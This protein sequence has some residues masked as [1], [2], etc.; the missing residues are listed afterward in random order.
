M[1]TAFTTLFLFN[2][3]ISKWWLQTKRILHEGVWYRQVTISFQ[4]VN[5]FKSSL[6]L[7]SKCSKKQSNA[8]KKIWLFQSNDYKWTA[9]YMKVSGIDRLLFLFNLWTN[10]N[11]VCLDHQGVARNNQT[12]IKNYQYFKW[13]QM[14]RILHEGVCYRQ[15]T[16]KQN[17][18]G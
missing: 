12:Q 4:F 16:V 1:C 7:T 2:I 11:L 9:F 3:S 15:V 8:D 10:S 5:K 6:S 17:Q 14:K 18:T 13:L